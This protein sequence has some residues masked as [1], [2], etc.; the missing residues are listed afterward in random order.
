M[1]IRIFCPLVDVPYKH[2]SLNQRVLNSAVF[3]SVFI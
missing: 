3:F 2:K 1:T